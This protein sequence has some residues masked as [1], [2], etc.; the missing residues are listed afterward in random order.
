MKL[1]FKKLIMKLRFERF[2]RKEFIENGIHTLMIVDTLKYEEIVFKIYSNTSDYFKSL[3]LLYLV[4]DEY[5]KDFD[6][7]TTIVLDY[8]ADI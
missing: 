1:H 5:N 7:Y 4:I 2:E 8:C 3:A 6:S